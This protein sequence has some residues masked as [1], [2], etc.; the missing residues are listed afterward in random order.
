LCIATTET[1]DGGARVEGGHDRVV[2]IDTTVGRNVVL[3]TMAA[4]PRAF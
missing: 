1:L 4:S 2:G 3:V